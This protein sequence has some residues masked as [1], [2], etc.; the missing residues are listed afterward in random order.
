MFSDFFFS[1]N[2]AV[3][4]IMWK[5]SVEPERPQM[6]IWRMRISRWIR[7]VT[8]LQTEYVTLIALPLQQ[9]LHERTSL[10]RYTYITWLKFWSKS[11]KDNERNIYIHV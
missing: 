3:Y 11:E 9:W 8:D 6:T 5:N 10:L 7:K 1:E 4:E 2:H